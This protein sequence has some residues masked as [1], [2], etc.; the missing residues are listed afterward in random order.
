V[1]GEPKEGENAY[2]GAPV[3]TSS[4]GENLTLESTGTTEEQAF[5]AT[6]AG[7]K[8]Q[9]LSTRKACL[10]SNEQACSSR[11]HWAEHP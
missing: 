10:T 9:I 1:V 4:S 7:S 8:C 6:F 3:N 5:E 2:P 11:A